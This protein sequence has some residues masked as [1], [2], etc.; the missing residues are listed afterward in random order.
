MSVEIL[1]SREAQR[2][3]LQLKRFN[4]ALFN[5]LRS[6]V[7]E[8]LLENGSVDSSYNPH[9]LDNPRGLYSGYM[10]FHLGDDILVLYYPPYPKKFLR[11]QRICSHEELR[12]GIFNASWR[13]C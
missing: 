7:A 12:T 3:L 6:I 1:F 9:V 4:R 11:I 5:E 8:S 2:D 13:D 10:E